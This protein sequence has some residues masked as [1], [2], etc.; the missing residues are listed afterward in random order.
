M[1][2]RRCGAGTCTF[3]RVLRPPYHGC[4]ILLPDAEGT[5]ASTIAAS[6]IVMGVK[7]ILQAEGLAIVVGGREALL[8]MLASGRPVLAAHGPYTAAGAAART[9]IRIDLHQD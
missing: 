1:W 9:P 6:S 4:S 5:A 7:K 2:H 8:E 3:E